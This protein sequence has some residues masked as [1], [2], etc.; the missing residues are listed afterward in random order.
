MTK[1]AKVE[2]LKYVDDMMK[3]GKKTLGFAV[4]GAPL[5]LCKAVFK[6][7]KKYYND[8]YW[9]VLVGWYRKA[10]AY[11]QIITGGMPE[12]EEP[13]PEVKIEEKSKDKGV[14]LMGGHVGRG[15]VK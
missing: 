6:E 8:L 9:P 2:S 11:D 15:V 5:W 3:E 4:G 10:K 12:F 1:D 7:A 14:S 13:A